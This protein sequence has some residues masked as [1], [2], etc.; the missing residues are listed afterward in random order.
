[1]MRAGIN[2]K[3]QYTYIYITIPMGT[4]L[5]TNNIHDNSS[6]VFHWHISSPG[7]DR[8]FKKKLK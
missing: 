1:M 2:T 6:L 7:I 5:H 8:I 3:L 4:K